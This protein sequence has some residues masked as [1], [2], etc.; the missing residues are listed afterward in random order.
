MSWL[1]T[2]NQCGIFCP[3]FPNSLSGSAIDR[4]RPVLQ[5]LADLYLGLDDRMS[6]GNGLILP[7]TPEGEE[8]SR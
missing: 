2:L 7:Y 1:R 6:D 5:L 4:R 8:W 3:V